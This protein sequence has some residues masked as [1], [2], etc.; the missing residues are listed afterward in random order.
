EGTER[1]MLASHRFCLKSPTVLPLR[2][3][4]QG[5]VNAV[6]QNRGS[7]A[8]RTLRRAAATPVGQPNYRSLYEILDVVDGRLQHAFLFW[9]LSDTHYA[10]LPSGKPPG[11]TPCR[12]SHS[13][14]VS[15]VPAEKKRRPR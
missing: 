15:S 9:W 8:A 14:N 6:G 10:R 4:Q 2:P 1:E 3:S 11:R 5:P 13:R 12:C 7:G